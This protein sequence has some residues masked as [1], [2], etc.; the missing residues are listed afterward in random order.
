MVLVWGQE[1]LM[2]ACG[3]L[4]QVQNVYKSFWLGPQRALPSPDP[5]GPL[6]T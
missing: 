3:D 1:P 4:V 6:R 2:A 5:Q